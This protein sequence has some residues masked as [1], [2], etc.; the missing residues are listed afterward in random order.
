[1][2]GSVKIFTAKSKLGPAKYVFFKGEQR[3]SGNPDTDFPE[4]KCPHINFGRHWFKIY[5]VV[6]ECV[7]FKELFLQ[8]SPLDYPVNHDIWLYFTM[9][10]THFFQFFHK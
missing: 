7:F 5:F 2:C 3:Q 6:L 1:M 9:Q 10:K 8:L 4:K